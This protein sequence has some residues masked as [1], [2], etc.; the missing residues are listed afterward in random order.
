MDITPV[1]GEYEKDFV[2]VGGCV[3][4]LS[5]WNRNG[6]STDQIAQDPTGSSSI[7]WGYIIGIPLMER[8]NGLPLGKNRSGLLRGCVDNPN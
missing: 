4:L 3:P 7:F 8:P 6:G 1:L 2:V 5:W